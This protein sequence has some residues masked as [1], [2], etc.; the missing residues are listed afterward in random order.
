MSFLLSIG[1][2]GV[3][4]PVPGSPEGLNDGGLFIKTK[5]RKDHMVL[6]SGFPPLK[7]QLLSPWTLDGL[8]MSLCFKGKFEMPMHSASPPL[9]KVTVPSFC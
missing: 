3:D 8:R 4:G 1:L 9:P 2:L 7:S 6:S 5:I